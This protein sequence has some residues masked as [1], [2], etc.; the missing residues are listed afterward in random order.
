[1]FNDDLK[2]NLPDSFPAKDYSGFMVAARTVMLPNITDAW[3]E[4][5]GASNLIGWRFRSTYEDMK[6][7][8]NLLGEK[9]SHDGMYKRE[10][11]LFSM[12]SSGVSC[13]ES[14]SYAVYALASHPDVLKIPFGKKQQRKSEPEQLLIALRPY[15][16]AE[17]LVSELTSI[18]NAKNWKTWKYLRNRM[19]HR[20]NLPR[21]ISLSTVR[22]VPQ[23]IGEHY[24]ETSSTESFE[25]NEASLENLFVW[26]TKTLSQLLKGGC[27]LSKKT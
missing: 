13:I 20:S 9:E 15:P 8:I 18:S 1:M 12:F 7:Y 11:A 4:F 21:I 6:T 3:K 2:L 26:L 5:A 23:K 14:T 19:S 27:S 22:D 16:S 25:A 17:M 24:A 10:R